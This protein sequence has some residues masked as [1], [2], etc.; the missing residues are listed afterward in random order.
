MLK[1]DFLFLN[2]STSAPI[3]HCFHGGLAFTFHL[4]WLF[5][6][7]RTLECF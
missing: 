1:Q 3:I 2:V 6:S 4:C 5:G 7:N